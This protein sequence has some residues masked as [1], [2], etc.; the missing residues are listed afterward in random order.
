MWVLIVIIYAFA[1]GATSFAMHDFSTQETCE[2]A[3][4]LAASSLGGPLHVSAVC[5][6]K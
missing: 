2:K 6:A 5:T 1:P 3:R 4:A